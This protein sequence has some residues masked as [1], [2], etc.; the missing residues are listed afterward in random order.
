MKQNK[1]TRKLLVRCDDRVVDKAG[2]DRGT[3]R[4]HS[5]LRHLLQVEDHVFIRW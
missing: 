1:L 3:R 2:E 5:Y 4:T